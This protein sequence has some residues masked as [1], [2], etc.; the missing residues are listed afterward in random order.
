MTMV[1]TIKKQ[2][3]GGRGEQ[4]DRVEIYSGRSHQLLVVADGMGGHQGGALA[5]QA[6]VD[7]A[8]VIFEG[9]DGQ[10]GSI[11]ESLRRLVR[12][13]HR[14]VNAIGDSLGLAPR[15]T[16]AALWLG[17]DEG[18]WAHVGDCRVYHFRQGSPVKRT[19][20]HSVVQLLLEMGKITEEEM[21]T[22]PN[23][24]RLLA[25]IGGDSGSDPGLDSVKTLPGDGFLLC[26]DGF[27]E[28]VSPQEM[29]V[30]WVAPKFE[31]SLEALVALAAKRGGAGGDNL[32]VA[33]ARLVPDEPSWLTRLWRGVAGKGRG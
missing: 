28:R 31:E 22:H 16:M 23:Q 4:Q 14:D 11:A 12:E 20:D 7:R 21:A 15:S 5:S 30:L 3:I 1:Q 29:E 6:V 33:A 9:W 13:A 25:G 27:W 26:S 17:P 18:Q 24:N 19:K 2:H 8:R 32:S 10:S